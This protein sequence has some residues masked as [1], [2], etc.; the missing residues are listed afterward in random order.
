M[1][2]EYNNILFYVKI[3]FWLTNISHANLI[4]KKILW[5]LAFG[6]KTVP[7]RHDYRF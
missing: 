4:V 3:P 7:L 6:L 2:K 5:L 1:D